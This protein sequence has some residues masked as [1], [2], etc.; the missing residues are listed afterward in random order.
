MINDEDGPLEEEILGVSIHLPSA[1]A[2]V[3]E[4]TMDS[5]EGEKEI[6]IQAVQRKEKLVILGDQSIPILEWLRQ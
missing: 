6:D 3:P 4:V 2:A 1:E 5:L